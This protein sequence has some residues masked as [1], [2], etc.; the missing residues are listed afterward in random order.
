MKRCLPIITDS[1]A[2]DPT[3]GTGAVKIT[4]A[5]DPA[6]YDV[7]KRHN[8]PFVSIL[9]DDGTLL[10]DEEVVG[11]WKG[12]KRFHVRVGIVEELKKVGLYVGVEENKMNVPICAKSGDVIEPVLKPQWWV[13]CE[14]LRGEVVRRTRAGELRIAPRQSESEWYRWLEG[15]QDWC[16]SRQLWW[17]HRIPAYYVKVKGEEKQDED[18]DGKHWVVGRTREEAEEKARKLV[19]EGRQFE[20]DQDQDVLDTWF[21]SG[22]WPFSTLGWPDAQSEDF[23]RYY[24]T[25]ILETGW[26]ILFF[27]VARMCLLGVYLTGNMPFREVYCHAMIRDAHGR[28]MSKSLGN[29]IDPLDVIRGI[30]LEALHDKLEEGNLDEKEITK[31]KAGQKKDFP[32]GI[33]QC[34][35]DALRFALCAYSGGGRDI[36]LDILRVEGYRKFGNKIFNATRFA[37]LKLEGGYEAGREAKVSALFYSCF[38]FISMAMVY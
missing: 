15:I 7:G 5:H 1:I 18:E 36:N 32:K 2:V 23:K 34:G 11:K 24:P 17:G 3:F 22:L 27:W 6:D 33:P 30:S 19:G 28:K 20:L 31:A 13:D 38:L 9:K 16:V 26:D 10:D 37:M 29:V 25:S 8:L 14:K 4:P 21:S 12:M 35:T